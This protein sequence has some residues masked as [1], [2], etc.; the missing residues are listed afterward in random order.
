MKIKGKNSI[1]SPGVTSD[2]GIVRES[3]LTLVKKMQSGELVNP[4]AVEVEHE[5][6][7]RIGF[8]APKMG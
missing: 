1:E 3:V 5:K 2:C 6:S 8:P 7:A 4:V